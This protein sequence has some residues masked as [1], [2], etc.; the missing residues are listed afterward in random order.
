MAFPWMAAIGLGGSII[1]Q[2]EQNQAARAYASQVRASADLERKRILDATAPWTAAGDYGLTGLT[3]TIST[4]L[5]PKVGKQ[6]DVLAGQHNISLSNIGRN[7]RKALAES[8]LTWGSTGNQGKAR[9]EALQIGDTTTQAANAENLGYGTAQEN[10]KNTNLQN[11]LSALDSMASKG[12]SAL[13]YNVNAIRDVGSAYDNA[14]QIEAGNK[15]DFGAGLGQAGGAL[16]G[17]WLSGLDEATLQKLLG[18]KKSANT[19]TYT[20]EGG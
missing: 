17:N 4:Q 20:P 16:F 7:E 14:A 9:G 19:G 6:S 13:G 12:Q 11:Y 5:A 3:N 15:S 18:K 10:Y 2:N 1:G 8:N